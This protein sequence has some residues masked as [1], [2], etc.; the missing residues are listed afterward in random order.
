MSR[1]TSTW[2]TTTA[3]II[4]MSLG[5]WPQTTTTRIT[6]VITRSF[7]HWP[8]TTIATTQVILRSLA[9]DNKVNRLGKN[10]CAVLWCHQNVNISSKPSKAGIPHLLWITFHLSLLRQLCM[11]YYYLPTFLP[12]Y[13]PTHLPRDFLSKAWSWVLSLP[14]CLSVLQLSVNVN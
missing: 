8:Q 6:Q 10:D 2:T 9:A 13:L 5:H 3:Q 11:I 4:T 1:R 12:N 14:S 7:G